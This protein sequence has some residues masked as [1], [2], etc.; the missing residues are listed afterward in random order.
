MD[1]GAFSWTLVGPDGSQM[2]PG[3]FP[4]IPLKAFQL[5]GSRRGKTGLQVN[6]SVGGS[7]ALPWDRVPDP[8]F[9]VVLTFGPS[10]LSN[11]GNRTEPD[12]ASVGLSIL[13]CVLGAANGTVRTVCR[14]LPLLL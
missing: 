14:T 2:D 13:P 4:W 1:S 6:V 8:A 5:K 12:E 11:F 7:G 10:L 3:G 9:V